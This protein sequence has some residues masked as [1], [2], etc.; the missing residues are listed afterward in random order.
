MAKSHISTSMAITVEYEQF[1]FLPMADTLLQ[2]A[3]IEKFTFGKVIR[4]SKHCRC[5]E[6]QPSFFLL[7]FVRMIS[8]RLRVVTTEFTSGIC[9][10]AARKVNSL[11][12]PDPWLLWISSIDFLFQAV[13]TRRSESGV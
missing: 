10:R 6:R 7:F 5:V 11:D 13:T 9:E 2:L 12:I 4:V 1:F 3:K 8:Q